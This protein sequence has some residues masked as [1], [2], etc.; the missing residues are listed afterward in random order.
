MAIAALAPSAPRGVSRCD[1]ERRGVPGHRHR[2]DQARPPAW[3]TTDGQLLARRQ[4]ADR[5]R[6]GRRGPVR[7]R[8]PDLVDEVVAPTGDDGLVVCGVGTGG[9][10]TAG[11]AH[12]SR[13]STS[14]RGATSRSGPPDGRT[15]A[16]PPWSTTTPRRWPSARAGSARR[17]GERDFLAMVVSTGVGGR[18]RPRRPAAGRPTGNAG[19]IGHVIVEPDGR[20]AV[21][22]AQGCLEAECSG[23]SI[24]AATGRPPEQA[25]SS[26]RAHRA[27]W[28]AGRWPRWPTS[29]TFPW[30]SSRG[31]VALGFGDDF[32]TA[33]QAELDRSC[34]LGLHPGDPDHSRRPGRRRAAG[35]GR[36]RRLAGLGRPDV[37][38]S[39]WRATSSR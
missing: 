4:P 36:R 30:P 34:R 7:R 15:P 10:M 16:C 28:W 11:G 37:T 39:P 5:R 12:V 8:S 2:R 9:P 14:R 13:R 25:T 29:S 22:G 3:W 6:H 27:R 17:A 38:R 31:S 33:A 26:T 24:E 18:H 35:R 1:T 19:H 23:P 32:F 20:P 21:C